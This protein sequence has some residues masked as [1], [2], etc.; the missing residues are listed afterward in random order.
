MRRLPRHTPLFLLPL[1]LA[2]LLLGWRCTAPA[3]LVHPDP[4]GDG[5]VDASDVAFVQACLGAATAAP[6]PSHDLYGCPLRAPADPCAPADVDGDGI[7]TGADLAEV[8]DRLGRTVC[9]GSEVLCGRRFDQVAYAT[10][11]NAMAATFPP[12]GYNLLYANQCS[13]VPTQLADGIR[14]LMLDVHW[15]QAPG[16]AA[17]D[18]YLCHADCNFGH[19][20]F[21]DGLAEIRAFLE[22]HPGEVLS[23]IFETDVDTVGREAEIRDAFAASGLLS[24]VHAQTRGDPWPTLGEMVA[25]G[26][27]LVVL[28][29]DPSNAG[30]G[31]ADPCPWYMYEWDQLAFETPFQAATPADFTCS[32]GR[33]EPGNDL[34][35]F[36]HFLTQNTSYIGFAA[37]VNPARVLGTRAEQCWA[38]QGR[39]PNFVTVDYYEIGDL[40]RV[41]DLLNYLWGRTG[42]AAP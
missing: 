11:H 20:R 35:I 22:A 17:P 15:Y 14:A 23:F 8:T 40:R 7:V 31:A 26:R 41:V 28:T 12:Y 25:S 18:L 32:D 5:V 21:V 34:M 42:G 27:R 19:Q 37:Q 33:G 9:N 3:F 39:I 13:G 16:D 36:N 24:Y 4:T 30:C 2:P 29:D 1:L 10:T 6:A 38:Y